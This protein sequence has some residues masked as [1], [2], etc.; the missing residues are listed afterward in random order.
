MLHN[1]LI[2]NYRSTEVHLISNV[3]VYMRQLSLLTTVTAATGESR[4][5]KY[6]TVKP[7]KIR[8]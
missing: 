6:S 2:Q 5:G 7:H 8:T 3:T 4:S 1:M